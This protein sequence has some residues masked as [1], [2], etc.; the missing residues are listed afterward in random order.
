MRANI[1]DISELETHEQRIYEAALFYAERHIPVV[2]IVPNGK[3]LP[4]KETGINYGSASYNKKT[5]DKWFKPDTGKYRGYNIG[6][7]CGKKGGFFALDV[8]RHGEHDGQANLDRALKEEDEDMPNCPVQLTP[9]KGKH[10]LFRWAEGGSPSTGKV[11]KGIDTRGGL[12]DKYKSHIVVF[13]SIVNQK[14]YHWEHWTN[15][16]PEIPGWI[17]RRLGKMWQ[18]RSKGNRG[19]E[20]VTDDDLEEAIPIE[21]AERMLAAINPDDLDYD[22]WLRIGMA[23][24]SQYPEEDGLDLWDAWS[25]RGERYKEGECEIRWDGFSDF[26]TVR[27]GTLFWHAQEH[28]W[29]PEKGDKQ[30]N[31]PDKI[32]AEMNE[33]FA[34]MMIGGKLRIL[35]ERWDPISTQ[36]NFTLYDKEAFI[37]YLS[38]QFVIVQMGDKQKQV[39]ISK[40]WLGHPGRRTYKNGMAL[41]PNEPAEDGYYNTWQGFAVEPRRG[42]CPLFLDHI[43][44]IMCNGNDDLN[45]WVLDWIADCF[46]DPGNPKGCAIVMRGAEGAGKGAVANTLGMLYGSH[47]RHLIDDSHLTSNFNAHMMDCLFVFADE[48]TWGGNKKTA[49]KLKGLITEPFLVGERKGVDAIMYR[50]MCHMMIASN[51][52]WVIPAGTNS[53]R[54]MVLDVNAKYTRDRP[55]FNELFKEIESD[56]GKAAILDYFINR[57]ISSDLRRAPETKALHT[58]QMMSASSDTV[59]NWWREKCLAGVVGALSAEGEHEDW[60]HHIKKMDMYQA[61]KTWA[62]DGRVHVVQENVFGK[63]IKELGLRSGRPTVGGKREHVY[64]MPVDKETAIEQLNKA[65][66]GAVLYDE[67]DPDNS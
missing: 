30:G 54:W 62:L 32:V 60:P 7:V 31:K 63:R 18:D 20:N 5:I 4:P 8:D 28:G 59:F 53:R 15:D 25:Q 52:E 57:R 19:N 48:I 42:D 10:Y 47:Y 41:F 44:Q 35:H 38:N 58:Q 23:I 55:Y 26:G 61:Y 67:D 12:E 24:K 45:T 34:V 13:P 14:M 49:G 40:I 16:I 9:N 65:M 1:Q 43:H 21:Q 37:G 46:Q 51:E 3:M 22:Q 66:P 36:P 56:E 39:E 27:A 6:L 50:N 17:V 11:A 29:E 64:F 2:P 33:E